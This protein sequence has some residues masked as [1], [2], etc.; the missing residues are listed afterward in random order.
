[1]RIFFFCLL[2]LPIAMSAQGIQFE[3]SSWE[4]LLAKAK[5]DQ[6]LIFLD[7][8][9]AWCGPCKMMS[10]QTFTDK[11]VG[12]FYNASFV[13]AKIDMEKGEG[14]QL[15]SRYRVE[16]YPTLL[17]V[18]G[19]GNVVHRAL[20]YHDVAQFIALGTAANDPA[21]NQRSFDQ[22][23]AGG[24][25]EPAFMAAYLASKAAADDPGVSQIATD[26]LATQTDWTTPANRQIIQNYANEPSSAPYAYFMKNRA[27]FVEQF[28]EEAVVNKAQVALGQY[29]QTHSEAPLNE[30]QESIRQIIGG[31][32]GE[33]LAVYYP[34]VFYQQ[35]G[36]IDKYAAA[37]LAYFE[38]YPPDNWN[39]LNEMAWAFYEN[40]SD[41]KMLET[42]LGWAKKSVEMDANYPNTDTLAALYA[43][44]G[45]KKQ[46]IKY[47]KQ[48]IELAKKSGDDYSAT[49]NLLEGLEK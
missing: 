49:Q 7:A 18:D 33:K 29:L 1:M 37:A 10:N 6:K 34:I 5:A 36:E 8:Y 39:I 31:E 41:P 3:H 20:G 16:A 14:P 23:Y 9:A 40:V 45:K 22:R 42:A 38:R 15:A 27:Q 28:G 24:D 30:V 46:A 11:E 17:F 26:F 12:K 47:A 13:N 4:A 48:A 21:T 32:Q 43:K 19:E 44:L 25:R 35:A 2:S